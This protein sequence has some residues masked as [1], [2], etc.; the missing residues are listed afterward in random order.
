M[1][2]QQNRMGM[3][4]QD[5]QMVIIF[6]R[7]YQHG[8]YLFFIWLLYRS[9][10][11]F[12]GNVKVSNKLNEYICVFGWFDVPI[13]RKNN[14]NSSIACP[15]KC[16][17]F[18]Y[19]QFILDIFWSNSIPLCWLHINIPLFVCYSFLLII[20]YWDKS[21]EILLLLMLFC[22]HWTF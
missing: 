14:N 15:H 13:Y 19:L 10:L 18:L 6:S 5:P 20:Q 11:V 12:H 16:L 9:N 17:I 1:G 3:D 22:I 2:M 8:F 21:V 4:P 7:W